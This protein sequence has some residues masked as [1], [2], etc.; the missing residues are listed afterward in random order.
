MGFWIVYLW[1]LDELMRLKLDLIV[2][3]RFLLML[4]DEKI[5]CEY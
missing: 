5:D 4:N 3:L 1:K 2:V